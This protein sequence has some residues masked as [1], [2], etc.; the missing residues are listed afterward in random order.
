MRKRSLIAVWLMLPLL[1]DDRSFQLLSATQTT[2]FNVTATGAIHLESSFGE[3]DIQGWDRPEVEVTATRST[4]HA[5]GPQD[6]AA[7]QKR[8]DSVQV[9]TKQDG[10]NLV[11]STLYPARSF[12]LHALS[13]RSDIEIHYEIHAPRASKLIIDHNSGGMNISG[14]HGAVHATVI[15]GQIT[16]MLAPGLYA[17]DAQCGLGNVYSDFA[18]LD[19]S[20]RLIGR[21][22]SGEAAAPAINLYLR[23]RVGDIVLLQPSGPAD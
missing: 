16:L 22:F 21:K 5:Y 11:I 6:L 13:R 10:N 4:E 15:N 1:A 17:I 20:R 18:G 23:A 9:N 3:A 2:R 8:L 12:F 14:M 7:A 19:R